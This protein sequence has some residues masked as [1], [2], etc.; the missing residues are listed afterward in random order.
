MP[1]G[2]RFLQVEIKLP[3]SG[4]LV[5]LDQ[6]LALHVN[7]HKDALAIQNSAEIT[8]FNLT[9][10]L[11]QQLL[12]SFTAFN[13]RQI[14]TGAANAA[15][16]YC[17]VT[18]T[19]GYLNSTSS[20]LNNGDP[21]NG[22]NSTIIFQGAIVHVEPIGAP[23]NQGVMIH[24]FEHQINKL[25]FITGFAPSSTTFKSYVQW[26]GAQMGVDRVVC[27]T[28]YDNKVISNPGGSAHTVEDLLLDIQ[29]LYRPAVAA[30]IDN[31]DLIVTDINKVVAS[32]GV[33]TV[34][35]FIGMP[36]WTEYGVQFRSM[37]DP[38]I[39]LAGQVNLKSTTNPSLNHS[40]IVSSLDYDLASRD[41]AFYGTVNANPAA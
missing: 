27:Q 12:S 17:Q 1:L 28:S 37:F 38:Q 15:D 22:N 30:F 10:S 33:T 2:Q 13:K 40:Y 34:S 35:E 41:E 14:E 9:Q 19:A 31:N 8:V 5:T 21:N 18:I 4:Q 32:R 6:T 25:K 24:C 7:I 16:S 3:Q 29:S 36:L 20:A 39:L 23:P 11:R 26:A